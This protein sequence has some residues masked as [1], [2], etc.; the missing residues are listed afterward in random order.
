MQIKLQ[1]YFLVHACLLLRATFFKNRAG[2]NREKS[3]PSISQSN[4]NQIDF[5][6]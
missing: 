6:K 5:Y 4:Q 1:L 3:T 2:S